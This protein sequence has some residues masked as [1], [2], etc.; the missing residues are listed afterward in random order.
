MVLV[1]SSTP[2]EAMSRV[3]AICQRKCQICQVCGRISQ[4]KARFTPKIALNF[5]GT[6]RF[7]PIPWQSS[8]ENC[9]QADWPALRPCLFAQGRRSETRRDCPSVPISQGHNQFSLRY[10]LHFRTMAAP[11]PT[12]GAPPN[13]GCQPRFSDFWNIV[14][15]VWTICLKFPFSIVEGSAKVTE[16]KTRR[17]GGFHE[18]PSNSRKGRSHPSGP[19]LHMGGY[20]GH[21]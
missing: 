11:L 10:A 21:L 12:P 9:G 4:G 8:R 17:N 13:T 15:F 19:G 1:Q 20:P 3:W 14:L 5:P 7:S 16:Y 2:G 18:H 6:I